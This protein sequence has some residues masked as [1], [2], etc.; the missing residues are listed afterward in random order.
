LRRHTLTPVTSQCRRRDKNASL[1]P[2]DWAGWKNTEVTTL[3][4]ATVRAQYGT[5]AVRAKKAEKR[6]GE[7]HLADC[8]GVASQGGPQNPFDQLRIRPTLLFHRH[9]HQIT[10]FGAQTR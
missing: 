10:R 8:T 5:G 6:S 3:I 4:E 9:Q 2:K 1:A 7:M